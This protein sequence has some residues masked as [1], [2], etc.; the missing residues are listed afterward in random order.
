M[1]SWQLSDGTLKHVG[2]RHLDK[3]QHRFNVHMPPLG[4][5]ALPLRTMVA[6]ERD[7]DPPLWLDAVTGKDTEPPPFADRFPVWISPNGQYLAF[8]ERD[9]LE[10]TTD[11][12]FT[13]GDVEPDRP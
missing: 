13:P 9:H 5:T 11:P 6:V 8:Q 3:W 7:N 10:L 2:G 4:T 1:K 12:A